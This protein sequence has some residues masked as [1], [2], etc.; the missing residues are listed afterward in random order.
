MEFI[1]QYEILFKKS[2]SDLGTSKVL[3]K[4]FEDGGMELELEI[5]MFHLQQCAEKLFKSLLAY[6]KHHFTKTHDLELL[7]ENI[8]NEKI[9][10]IDNIESLLPLSEYAV[11]GRY[12]IIHDDIEDA[13][14]YIELLEKFKLFVKEIVVDF[15][16]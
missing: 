10:I 15:E 9:E 7:L 2:T 4:S 11:D 12:A 5:I 16:E 13:H 8:R 14:Q 1:K 3:L 6:N